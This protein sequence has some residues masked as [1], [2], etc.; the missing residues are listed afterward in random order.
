M[1]NHGTS[2]REFL[3]AGGLG[4]LGLAAITPPT[5]AKAAG[6]LPEQKFYMLLSCG[7]IGV[8]ASFRESVELAVKYGFEGVDPDAGYFARLSDDEL[9]RLLDELKAKNLRLGAAGLPVDFRKDEATFSEGLKKL[10]AVAQVLQN[11][12][13]TRVSTWIM[14]C[15]NEL[16]YLQNFR[17]HASRLRLCATILADH[18]QRLGLEYV[19]PKTLWRSQKHPFLHTLSETKELLVAIGTDNLGVQLDSWHWFNAE[20]TEEDLLTLRNQDVVTVDLNDAPTGIPLE[21]QVDSAR[22]LPAATGVIPVK[23]FLEALRKISYGGPVQAE[24][25]NAA[26]R[27]M[28]RDEAVA[29]TAAAMKKAFAL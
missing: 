5:A 16:T 28:P 17:S 9:K 11:A 26:L 15:S 22:E 7:R 29:A 13:V 21:K 1:S 3:L 2:R 19:S 10:P 4:A 24:P 14:P 12:G 8:K 20:E 25:F 23:M 18:G 6:E 27:A